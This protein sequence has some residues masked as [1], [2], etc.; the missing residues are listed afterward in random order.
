MFTY[1]LDLSTASFYQEDPIP[2]DPSPVLIKTL[3]KVHASPLCPKF[4]QV[5][6]PIHT[7]GE[8]QPGMAAAV[9]APD[10][11]RRP[12]VYPMKWGFRTP[13][14]T[15][16]STCKKADDHRCVIPS[17]WLIRDGCIMQTKGSRE[18]WIAGQYRIEN[19]LP[20]FT[21][22]TVPAEFYTG[23]QGQSPAILRQE[24]IR[25]WLKGETVEYVNEFV[26]ERL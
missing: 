6:L 2:H 15:L 18:T 1:Y 3:E 8:V 21:V 7:A 5:A 24:D 22:L 10:K 13:S 11:E 16:I 12:T 17:S 14:G 19:G 23:E 4:I 9:I 20:A 25:R 26:V